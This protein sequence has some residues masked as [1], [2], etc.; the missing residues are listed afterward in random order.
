MVTFQ[1][2]GVRTSTYLFMGNTIQPIISTN[3][4]FYIMAVFCF[5]FH[6]DMHVHAHYAHTNILRV[7][8][9]WSLGELVMGIWKYV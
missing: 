9:P 7:P 6:Q 8:L 4:T 1:A 3:P 5:T 2:I